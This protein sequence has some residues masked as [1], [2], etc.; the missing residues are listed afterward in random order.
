MSCDKCKGKGRYYVKTAPGQAQ[1]FTCE[2]CPAGEEVRAADRL[3]SR[4]TLGTEREQLIDAGRGR[5]L[6]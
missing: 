4:A 6:R 2:L 3:C 1:G 5:L